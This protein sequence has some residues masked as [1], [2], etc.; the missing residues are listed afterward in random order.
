VHVNAEHVI[1]TAE[2]KARELLDQR[3]ESVR[4]VVRAQHDVTTLR[5]QLTEAEREASRL[6]RSAIADGWSDAELRK[7]GITES[8]T[9][10]ARRRTSRASAEQP[11]ASAEQPLS[12]A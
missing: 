7:L 3:I 4:A 11:S 10:P 5:E 6:Y 8:G 12:E 2:R 1:E 9:K